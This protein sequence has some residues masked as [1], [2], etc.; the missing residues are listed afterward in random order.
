M[1]TSRGNRLS[2]A[3]QPVEPL[4]PQLGK[5]ISLGAI[6]T[7]P[8][9]WQ[10][11]RNTRPDAARCGIT[12][13]SMRSC[14]FIS[15]TGHAVLLAA[16][17]VFAGARPF[18]EL[19]AEAIAVD[20]VSPD[21]IDI[22]PDNQPPVPSPRDFADLPAQPAPAAY[23]GAASQTPVEP[24]PK[25]PEPKRDRRQAA[26][27][28]PAPPATP[29]AHFPPPQ[30]PTFS[31]PLPAGEPDGASSKTSVAD[32]FALPLTLPG[33][34][35][36]GSFDAPAIDRADIGA[37]ETAA[38]RKHVRSCASLPPALGSDDKVRIV[39]RISLRPDGTLAGDPTL[40]EAS[41]SAKGVALMQSAI[42][43]LQRCQ[44]YSMLPADKYSE[45][46]ALDLSFTPRD[47]GR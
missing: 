21:E 31:D 27:A 12:A 5:A 3:F 25:R 2:G 1:K 4:C 37:E 44:P 26:D 16:T 41:A 24:A 30:F 13:K 23:E 19:S 6:E 8:L 40:I 39:L 17:F 11:K 46:K 47:M 43:A 45:W 14:L 15:A 28:Q 20:I 33:G 42:R 38:F 9:C 22:A 36:G 29:A 32:L 35:L 18:D 10:V 34:R 7:A